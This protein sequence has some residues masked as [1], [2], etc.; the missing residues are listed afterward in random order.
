M[1]IGLQRFGH[2]DLVNYHEYT[3]KSNL[4]GCLSNTLMYATESCIHVLFAQEVTLVKKSKTQTYFLFLPAK[5]SA[6]Y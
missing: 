5:F 1:L 6:K 3:C 2:K 4:Y